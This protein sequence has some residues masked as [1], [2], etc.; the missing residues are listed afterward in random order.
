LGVLAWWL[1]VKALIFVL[2]LGSN[3]ESIAQTPRLG[4]LIVEIAFLILLVVS[5]FVHGWIKQKQI[6][7]NIDGI[8]D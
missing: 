2:R 8:F 5:S 3:S 6:N 1:G 4:S 7:Q